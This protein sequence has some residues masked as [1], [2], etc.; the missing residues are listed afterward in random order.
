MKL[1][2]TI[3]TL[4]LFA[5]PLIASADPI[6]TVRPSLAP[7]VF[8]S[9]SFPQ[10]TQNAVTALQLGVSSFGNPASPTFYQQT[11]NVLASQTIVT[12]FPS[13]MGVVDPGNAFGA[14]YANELG[15]RMTF[16]VHI[17]GNGTQFSISQMSFVGV[18]SD[19]ANILGFSFA[20]GTYNYSSA[21]V[22]L[23][24][25]GDGIKGTG[26][27]F[28]V[29]AGPNT[30]L[31]DE[32][33]GRGSGN[34]L[35]AQCFGCTLAEQQ[36]AI[37]LAAAYFSEPTAFTGTYSLGNTSGS[38]T[39]G[40]QPVPEPGT[41]ILLGTGLLGALGKFG[42]VDGLRRRFSRKSGVE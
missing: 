36:A 20:A 15:N 27:D 39:F 4:A 14:A 23:N 40:I 25:G 2:L 19:G 1:R 33:F 34:S 32:L 22:G 10:Y 24:Y 12:G 38:G 42:G 30:Q 41:L 5:F 21:Y 11:S 26:D 29:T 35:E 7:N 8:G 16:G 9:P 28:F 3:L 37:D 18:S 31:V 6:I 17:F 13:W